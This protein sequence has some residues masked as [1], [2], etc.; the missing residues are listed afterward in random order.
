MRV[1]E[2]TEHVPFTFPVRT[3][4]LRVVVAIALLVST[5]GCLHFGEPRGE[6]YTPYEPSVQ[7]RLDS[8]DVPE[9]H[10][11][12]TLQDTETVEYWIVA[13]VN[14]ERVEDGVEPLVWSPRLAQVA[15]Y[16]SYD[17]WNRDYFAHRYNGTPVYLHTLEH[18][19]FTEGQETAENIA[20][21]AYGRWTNN[22][23]GPGTATYRDPKEFA[24]ALV[25]GWMNSGGHRWALM[26]GDYTVTGVGVYGEPDGNTKATQLFADRERFDEA[27]NANTTDEFRVPIADEDPMKDETGVEPY[28]ERLGANTPDD[29]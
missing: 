2:S 16:R 3:H 24:R 11:N 14:H 6:P 28:P 9:T 26:H 27:V 23:S 15:D 29:E 10:P 19:K 13:Y 18:F 22:V 12:A 4:T 21:V 1:E 5:A 17:M 7:Q 20:S 8:R 25:R